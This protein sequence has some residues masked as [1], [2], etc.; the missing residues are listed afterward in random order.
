MT[1]QDAVLNAAAFER[2]A[3]VR[4]TIVEGEDTSVVVDDKDRTVMTAKNKASLSFQLVK[5]AR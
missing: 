5:P 2:E 1:G 3:H 4:A